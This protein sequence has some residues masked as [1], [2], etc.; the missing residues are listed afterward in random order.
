MCKPVK[1][2]SII[3]EEGKVKQSFNIANCKNLGIFDVIAEEFT[4]ACNNT[5]GRVIMKKNHTIIEM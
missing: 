5:T 2:F 1:N 3:K 4:K